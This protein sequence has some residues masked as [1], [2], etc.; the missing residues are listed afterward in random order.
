M[1]GKRQLKGLFALTVAVYFSSCAS[2]DLSETHTQILDDYKAYNVRLDRLTAPLLAASADLCPRQASDNGIRWHKISDYPE[3]LQDAA[4]THWALTETLSVFFVTPQS[5]AALAGVKPGDMLSKK[6]I[7]ALGDDNIVCGYP[8]LIRYSGEIN[9]YATGDEIIVTAAMMRAI[10]DD[11]YLRLVIAHELSHNI[12]GHADEDEFSQELENE[13]DRM[14]LF[15]LARAGF[16]FEKAVRNRA[17]TRKKLIRS[18]EV[19]IEEKERIVR[20]EKTVEEIKALQKAGK[21]LTP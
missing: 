1:R 11:M 3:A 2:T 7:A 12:L 8:V 9:A 20:F 15:L 4:R 14:G 17:A 5:S 6:Q 21:P 18:R 10:K 19:P 13:A 16:D